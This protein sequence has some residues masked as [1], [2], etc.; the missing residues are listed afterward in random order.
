MKAL[1]CK[2]ERQCA[3]R[4][5]HPAARASFETAGLAGKSTLRAPRK[6]VSS[7]RMASCQQKA[8][9]NVRRA[10]ATPS[11][12]PHLRHV[13]AKRTPPV[14]HLEED[15]TRGPHIDLLTAISDQ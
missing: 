6:M 10:K 2:D 8:S 7:R 11:T 9:V 3:G 13:M 5:R 1:A 12:A 15:H 4:R 14:Q